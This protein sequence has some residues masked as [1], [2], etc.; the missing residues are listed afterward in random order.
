MSDDESEVD[1][2]ARRD[3]DEPLTDE[4]K[5]AVKPYA[6]I[7][8]AIKTLP[9]VEPPEGWEDRAILVHRAT[10]AMTRLLADALP[11]VEPVFSVKAD[12]DGVEVTLRL[13][14][15]SVDAL[16]PDERDIDRVAGALCRDVWRTVHNVAA[17][18]NLDISDAVRA[19]R[20][21]FGRGEAM[22]VADLWRLK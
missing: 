3:R 7:V 4:E 2:I 17:H 1:L 6:S 13:T 9:S 16:D 14:A 15:G 11:G 18:A 10:K 5:R 8:Q 20:V 21:L 12:G 19:L 22:R